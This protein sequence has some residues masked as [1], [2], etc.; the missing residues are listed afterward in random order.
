MEER[1]IMIREREAEMYEERRR[2]LKRY[3]L[4]ITS[5]V[6]NKCSREVFETLLGQ[7]IDVE[8]EM[9]KTRAALRTLLES[10]DPRDREKIPQVRKELWEL[11]HLAQAYRCVLIRIL[12]RMIRKE[13]EVRLGVGVWEE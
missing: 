9:L 5:R 1:G 3:I 2:I 6:G 13:A 10:D 7:A 11:T 4:D 12:A 8:A